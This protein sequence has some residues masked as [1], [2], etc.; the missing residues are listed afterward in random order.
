MKGKN[1]NR[2]WIVLAVVFGNKLLNIFMYN[3]INEV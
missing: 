1:S 3:A 2:I